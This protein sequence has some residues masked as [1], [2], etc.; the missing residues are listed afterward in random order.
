M[1]HLANDIPTNL[2]EVRYWYIHLKFILFYLYFNAERST[3]TRSGIKSSD[4]RPVPPRAFAATEKKNFCPVFVYKEYQKHRPVDMCNEESRFYLRP[5]VNPSTN[6]W[7]S[8]QV[9]GKDKLGKIMKEMAKEGNLEGRKVNHS[10]RKTFATTLIQNGNPVTEVAQL[11]GWKSISS[12]THYA[13]PSAEQQ[14]R[15]SNTISNLLV[16]NQESHDIASN[17][18]EICDN[19]DG[20]K[21]NISVI[22]LVPVVNGNIAPS[23]EI[24]N[25]VSTCSKMHSNESERRDMCLFQ[26]A[27]I[28]GGTININ[29]VTGTNKKSSTSQLLSS[30][31]VSSQE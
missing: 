12:L 16:P 18:D 5:I 30:E 25:Q 15:A 3:K 2:Q 21:N 23:S 10:G 20:N 17:D 9:I 31:F 19:F 22:D 4:V 26:N 14:E 7:Y 8:K 24:I 6:I 27:V 28:S 13:V 29:I 11:G 1:T